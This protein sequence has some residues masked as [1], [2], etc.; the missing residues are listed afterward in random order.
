MALRES[1]PHQ[2]RDCVE[3][4][5]GGCLFYHSRTQRYVSAAR[6]R[7]IMRVRIERLREEETMSKHDDNVVIFH[8][9]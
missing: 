3:R 7:I 9:T 4:I 6:R 8:S 1:H 2:C 5:F